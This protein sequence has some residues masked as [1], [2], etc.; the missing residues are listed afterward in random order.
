MAKSA[1]IINQPTTIIA[2]AADLVK[3]LVVVL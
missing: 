3:L 2:S 1:N